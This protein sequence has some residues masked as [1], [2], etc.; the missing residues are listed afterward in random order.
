[1][2]K[3]RESLK[4]IVYRSILDGIFT[5]E[6]KPNQIINEKELTDKFGYSKSPVREALIALCNEGVLKSIPRYGYEVIRLT[7]EDVEA[8]LNY[9]LVLE[10]GYLREYIS[11]ITPVQLESL[12]QLENSCCRDTADIWEHWEANTEFHLRLLSFSGNEYACRQLKTSMDT[13]KRA[14]AQFYWQ[15]WDTVTPSAD[16]RHHVNIIRALTE[17][18]FEQAASFLKEDLQDFG[19]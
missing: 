10:R 9:R 5:D 7:R 6:Y 11:R 3:D 15:R 8:I 19:V 14:Y 17:K 4:N 13:L 18:N 1:M 2:V 12:R 16:V